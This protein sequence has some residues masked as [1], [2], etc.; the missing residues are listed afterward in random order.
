MLKDEITKKSANAWL[1]RHQT[2]GTAFVIPAGHVFVM[3]GL[4]DCEKADV[5]SCI[6]WTYLKM[7]SKAQVTQCAN[8][9]TELIKG[10]ANLGEDANHKAWLK[11]LDAAKGNL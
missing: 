6:R 11:Y 10:Y 3:M 1:F 4:H 8:T 7:D 5:V 9:V 2:P